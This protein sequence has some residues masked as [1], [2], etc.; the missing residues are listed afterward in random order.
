MSDYYELWSEAQVAAFLGCNGETV[1]ELRADPEA[2]FPQP[3]ESGTEPRWKKDD[4]E[5]WEKDHLEDELWYQE[6]GEFFDDEY[7]ED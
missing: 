5:A 3:A 2:E 6:D 7:P 4:I 1:R